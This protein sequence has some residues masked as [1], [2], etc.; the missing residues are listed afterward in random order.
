M[1]RLIPITAFMLLFA[2]CLSG[3]VSI[4][5]TGNLPDGSSMLDISS[6]NSGILIQQV[7]LTGR[8]DI[9]T[10]PLA[11]ESL[12]IYNTTS[13]AELRPKFYF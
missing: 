5:T 6:S 2:F 7:A 8:T 3:Q 11:I 4:N 9:T 1:K 10:I 12:L 13:N